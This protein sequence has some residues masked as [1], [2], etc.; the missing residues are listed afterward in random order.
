MTINWKDVGE[1][2][3]WTFIEGALGTLTFNGTP[4]KAALI[5]A[6]MAGISALK[7]LI[8]EIARNQ[9]NK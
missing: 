5:G 7:T 4:D 6:V 9:L 2:A 3:V 1:R 8:L